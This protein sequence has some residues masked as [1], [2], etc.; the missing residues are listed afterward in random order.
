MKL[1]EFM[2]EASA[3]RREEVAQ[4]AETTVAYLYQLAGGHRAASALLARRIEN[5]TDGEVT[6]ADLRPDIFDDIASQVSAA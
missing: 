4:K 1:S 6:R 3:E 2:A 5:A